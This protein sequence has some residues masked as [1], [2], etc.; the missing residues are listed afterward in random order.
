MY[1]Q[2][3]IVASQ[4]FDILGIG[5]FLIGNSN[6]SRNLQPP[7]V[8]GV[9]RG[10]H[11]SQTRYPIAPVRRFNFFLQ[12]GFWCRLQSRSRA[13][14]CHFAL[15][16]NELSASHCEWHGAYLCKK[17]PRVAF[18]A[19][20]ACIDAK[21]CLR[22]NNRPDKP[23]RV[24]GKELPVTQQAVHWIDKGGRAITLEEEVSH[25]G[26]T[27]AHRWHSQSTRPW[28][29]HVQHAHQENSLHDGHLHKAMA[30]RTR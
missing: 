25:P 5:V 2:R 30:Q 12:D 24:V 29:L 27:V 22:R 1:T 14:F 16:K 18:L 7:D 28:R 21:K 23:L 8:E 19:P 6:R 15:R 11:R 20:E 17:E 10:P 3:R 4:E 26:E 9:H 13:S